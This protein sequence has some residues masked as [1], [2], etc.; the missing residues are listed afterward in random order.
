[1]PKR[2]QKSSAQTDASDPSVRINTFICRDFTRK[3]GRKIKVETK[4]N[5]TFKSFKTELQEEFG[6]EFDFNVYFDRHTI[7]NIQELFDLLDIANDAGRDDEEVIVRR[8]IKLNNIRS[9]KTELVLPDDSKFPYGVVLVDDEDPVHVRK[10]IKDVVIDF[11]DNALKEPTKASFQ[12]PSRSAENIGY[13]EELKMVLMGN[14]LTDKAF[15]N[16]SSVQSFSQ[17]AEMM[18]LIDAVLREKIHATKR[19]LFYRNPKLFGDQRVSD[20][21]I[22]DLGAMLRVTRNSLNVIASAKGKVLGRIQFTEGRDRIDCSQGLGGRAITPMTD[23]ITNL[24][25]DAEF[26]LVIEKD[27]AFQ[28][29]AEDRFFDFMPCIL[30]TASGQPDIATR[31]FVKKVR[32]ELDLPV[33]GFMDADPY[34]MD[35]LRVYTIGSKAKSLETYELAVTDIKWLG[36]LPSDLDKYNIP[37]SSRIPM[38][39]EDTKRAEDLLDEDFVRARPVWQ[40]EVEIMINTQEKAEIQALMS[41]ELRYMTN[42]Y[43]PEK[44]ES[45]D[46]L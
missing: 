14:L 9:L 36:L 12:I 15:R 39:K 20:G 24:E 22:E 19:D 18:K 1:M 42:V 43:L 25:S 10:R 33:F 8:K 30:V 17:F 3:N 27:A 6:I 34:G 32:E 26:V 31:L 44:L 11:V 2:T 13:D 16:L 41:H 45:G 38:T 40:R 23:Q 21:L 46:W 4:S 5:Q 7:S 28:R 35:I 37:T 29:L